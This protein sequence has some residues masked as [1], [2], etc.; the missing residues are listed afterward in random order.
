[1]TQIMNL[2]FLAPEIQEAILFLSGDTDVSEKM[3]RPITV[4]P[5][6]E[7]QRRLFEQR[8]RGISNVSWRR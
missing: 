5:S 6:W 4:Q 3:L 2:N 8:G 1:M 7:H